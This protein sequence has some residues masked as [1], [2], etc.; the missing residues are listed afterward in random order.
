MF[1]R[2]DLPNLPRLQ[3]LS[4]LLNIILVLAPNPWSSLLQE[5]K[6]Q[7]LCTTKMMRAVMVN[8]KS[9]RLEK[10]NLHKL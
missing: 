8:A 10:G 1:N 3:P 4:Y 5:F 2:I 7:A 6:E 9:N